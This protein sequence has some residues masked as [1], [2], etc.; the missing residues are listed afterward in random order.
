MEPP[1]QRTKRARRKSS[2]GA[3]GDSGR[4]QQYTGEGCS[5]RLAKLIIFYLC[6]MHHNRNITHFAFM[7]LGAVAL[8]FIFAPLAGMFL[9]VKAP[10]L[11]ETIRDPEVSRSIVLTLGVSAAATFISSVFAIPLAYI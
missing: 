7:L 6:Q 5:S 10:G 3:A 11:F 1:P 2:G 4:A 9:S 8:L